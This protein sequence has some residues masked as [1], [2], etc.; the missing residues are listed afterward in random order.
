[1][2]DIFLAIILGCLVGLGV[3]VSGMTKRL[4][5]VD[6]HLAAIER[7]TAR[8]VVVQEAQLREL[9]RG[10]KTSIDWTIPAVLPKVAEER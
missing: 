1:M 8:L 4:S 5:D 3:L 9:R 2:K 10:V 7:S 6:T